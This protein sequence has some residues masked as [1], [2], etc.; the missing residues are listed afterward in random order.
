MSQTGV[1]NV[2]PQV[3]EREASVEPDKEWTHPSGVIL[4]Y[5][6]GRIAARESGTESLA[7]DP[8]I[9]AA[10]GSPRILLDEIIG[11]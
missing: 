3:L 9:A 4:A 7:G 5:H 2:V 8:P 1:S 11:P 6:Q 10:A